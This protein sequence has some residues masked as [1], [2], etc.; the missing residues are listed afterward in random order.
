MLFRS[1]GVLLAIV[2]LT[3]EPLLLFVPV[4]YILIWVAKAIGSREL[5]FHSAQVE[6][7]VATERGHTPKNG[8][9]AE[10]SNIAG[11]IRD[12]GRR[13]GAGEE[14][15]KS[16]IGIGVVIIGIGGG[17]LA[18]LLQEPSLA[19]L[20]IV[21]AVIFY[22]ILNIIP[23]R[24]AAGYAFGEATNTGA[25][26]VG[27][28]AKAQ[29]RLSRNLLLGSVAI[30]TLAVIFIAAFLLIIAN[31]N[32]NP[33]VDS[34]RQYGLLYFVYTPEG[35]VWGIL[36]G[37]AGL[38]IW[39]GTRGLLE[40]IETGEGSQYNGSGDIGATD[41][42]G[43]YPPSGP[44]PIGGSSTT[45]IKR[46]ETEPGTGAFDKARDI[47]VP[48]LYIL[49]G[50][51]IAFVIVDLLIS[52]LEPILDIIYYTMGDIVGAFY[53]EKIL[54]T[55]L[56][57]FIIPLATGAFLG[58]A[59][60][61]IWKGTRGLLE[62][63]GRE[64][65]Q[66]PFAS[67]TTRTSDGRTTSLLGGGLL[68]TEVHFDS[69]AAVVL[70][71]A[72]AGLVIICCIAAGKILQKGASA[73]IKPYST[74]RTGSGGHIDG[75]TEDRCSVR[76][77]GLNNASLFRKLFGSWAISV[78]G[79]AA[80]AAI[81]IY[82]PMPLFGK[83]CMFFFILYGA[84][85]YFSRFF[86]RLKGMITTIGAILLFLS[87]AYLFAY[88]IKIFLGPIGL[89]D[90]LSGPKLYALLAAFSLPVILY[91]SLVFGTIIINATSD[92][93]GQAGYNYQSLGVYY[94]RRG[95]YTLAIRY[96]EKAGECALKAR[97]E[98]LRS[99]IAA[100]R[101]M[102]QM[103]KGDFIE[104]CQAAI[105]AIRRRVEQKR[106]EGSAEGLGS[107]ATA[108]VVRAGRRTYGF[109]PFVSENS[110]NDG[111]AA[112]ELD[113]AQSNVQQAIQRVFSA[114]VHSRRYFFLVD[115]QDKPVAF[116]EQVGPRTLI[117]ARPFTT[118][119]SPES[120]MRYYDILL[121]YL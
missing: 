30:A 105:K 15:M 83:L 29:R 104:E 96:F 93:Q 95:Q 14:G 64:G 72:V 108:L 23:G 89:N 52:T 114:F 99:A 74:N 75:K 40:A 22:V 24:D 10:V 13:L 98:A 91:L 90:L 25:E 4:L 94:R 71:V 12:I 65:S 39:K 2:F 38:M 18:F 43:G 56:A 112:L 118:L 57:L 117:A 6:A 115:A 119:A 51:A 7:S 84:M 70:F 19:V 34:L 11:R 17:I 31:A 62:A 109:P 100:D 61:M 36:I 82:L 101:V 21:G 44:A 106:D 37:L 116:T 88:G 55:L 85:W 113:T 81:F 9:W 63:I 20:C 49:I 103:R 77:A 79:F 48:I 86:Q 66:Q 110:F 80:V 5:D 26:R 60:L 35:F 69:F 42:R 50:L 67:G 73:L 107:S 53:G 3:K 47:L 32:I 120:F 111:C 92:E 45:A 1:P 41:N 27:K 16:F 28:I 58:L 59:G 97:S 87:S 76:N 46:E 102:M 33:G 68:A 8:S 121:A 78:L 54:D